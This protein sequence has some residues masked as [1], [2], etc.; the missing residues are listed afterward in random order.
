MALLLGFRVYS[1]CAYVSAVVGSSRECRHYAYP[2]TPPRHAMIL[3]ITSRLRPRSNDARRSS[4]DA[5]EPQRDFACSPGRFNRSLCRR[6]RFIRT[7]AM[8]RRSIEISFIGALMIGMQPLMRRSVMIMPV[9]ADVIL[10]GGCRVPAYFQMA[11]TPIRACRTLLPRSA[12]SSFLL[13][14]A[15]LG[16]LAPL[17]GRSASNIYAAMPGDGESASSMPPKRLLSRL[18][19]RCA[20]GVIN[21][22]ARAT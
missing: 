10:A 14:G 1:P 13:V 15:A 2:I 5:A 8:S 20:P 3:L 19:S 7:R 18:L 9:P 21:D 4:R 17:S 16:G 22:I 12:H 11:I 6:C